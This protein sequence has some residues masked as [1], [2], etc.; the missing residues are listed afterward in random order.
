MLLVSNGDNGT[1]SSTAAPLFVTLFPE[2]DSTCHL[3]LHQNSDDGKLCNKPL[4]YRAGQPL[5]GLMTLQNFLDGG[6]DVIDAKILVVVKSIGAK[7]KG[8]WTSHQSSWRHYL[9]TRI[10]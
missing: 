3:M 4:G 6:Y 9:L 2:R 7:K 10:Q 8:A 5:C 1:L